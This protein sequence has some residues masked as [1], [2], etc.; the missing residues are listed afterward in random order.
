MTIRADSTLAD[1]T[2]NLGENGLTTVEYWADERADLHIH[3]HENRSEVPPDNSDGVYG[4]VTDSSGW[5]RGM[6]KG[7]LT[8]EE[9][10][11]TFTMLGS[12]S[13]P[14]LPG[15]QPNRL[16][17]IIGVKNFTRDTSQNVDDPSLPVNPAYPPKT[18]LLVRSVQSL[19]SVEYH[20][21]MKRGGTDTDH[22]RIQITS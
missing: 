19:E 3:F 6:P 5:F 21:W 16:G 9:I 22:R 10:D 11:R 2:G 8:T 7:S 12:K 13:E 4:N 17:L 14:E 1:G 15:G 18:L 20:S